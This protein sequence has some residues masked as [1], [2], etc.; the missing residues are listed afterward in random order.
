M[1]WRM[2]RRGRHA[3]L[4]T[5]ERRQLVTLA[6]TL[7]W[8]VMPGVRNDY[9]QRCECFRLVQPDGTSRGVH[10]TEALE[11]LRAVGHPDAEL[12]M[13]LAGVG[14]GSFH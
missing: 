11:L 13:P 5:W 2:G 4:D 6:G 1:M 7:H 10:W 8:V 9:G 12:A 14:A 3:F